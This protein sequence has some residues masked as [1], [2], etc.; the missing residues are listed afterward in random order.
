M[1]QCESRP[2]AGACFSADGALLAALHADPD[3]HLALFDADTGKR[4]WN[5]PLGRL[6]EG[7]FAGPPHFSPDGKLISLA[8][9]H[10]KGGRPAAKLLLFDRGG[11]T[12]REVS[13]IPAHVDAFVWS[14]DGRRLA[15]YGSDG[16]VR[17][18]E[19]EGKSPPRE[20]RLFAG[21][22]TRGRVE[23]TADGRHLLVNNPNGTAYVLRLSSP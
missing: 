8:A 23:F 13:E 21:P 19:A 15:G 16:V 20:I 14:P 6:T 18:L 7:G 17:V 4:A 11:G 3:E 5:A 9:N 12:P 2:L 1:G 22:V 10:R